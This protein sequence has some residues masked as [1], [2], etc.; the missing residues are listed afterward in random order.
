MS[1][2]AWPLPLSLT[3]LI[4]VTKFLFVNHGFNTHSLTTVTRHLKLTVQLTTPY[5]L[6]LPPSVKLPKYHIFSCN[7]PESHYKRNT[8]YGI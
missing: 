7:M 3:F 4:K 1:T 5:I 2:Q 8:T 6:I